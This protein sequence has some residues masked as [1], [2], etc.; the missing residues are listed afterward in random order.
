VAQ[1]GGQELAPAPAGSGTGAGIPLRLT[2]V[3]GLLAILLACVRMP[4]QVNN[5][6]DG[7]LSAILT[8]GRFAAAGDLYDHWRGVN[9]LAENFQPLI[10]VPALLFPLWPSP[11]LPLLFDALLSGLAVG[12]GVHW[13]ALLLR[14]ARLAVVPGMLLVL[15]SGG[16]PGPG[17]LLLPVLLALPLQRPR[18]LAAAV[19]LLL[20][21]GSYAGTL[22]L[23]PALVCCALPRYRRTGLILLVVSLLAIAA[24]CTA[25]SF[26]PQPL[27]AGADSNVLLRLVSSG[28]LAAITAGVTVIIRRAEDCGCWRPV[29]LVAAVMTILTVVID[30]EPFMAELRESGAA[31]ARTGELLAVLRQHVPDARGVTLAVPKLLLPRVQPAL[32]SAASE[33]H[34][35]PWHEDWLLVDAR[36]PLREADAAF[37]QTRFAQRLARAVERGQ[38]GVVYCA[39]DIILLKRGLPAQAPAEF[40]AALDRRLAQAGAADTIFLTPATFFGRWYRSGFPLRASGADGGI[41]TLPA[42]VARLNSTV[43]V[44]ALGIDNRTTGKH[45]R[46]PWP[47]D[48]RYTGQ[49]FIP[50]EVLTA[51]DNE[52]RLTLWNGAAVGAAETVPVYYDV[53]PPVLRHD[54][55][56]RWWAG[57]DRGELRV[58]C[59]Q[60]S[61][62]VRL[63]TGNFNRLQ[64]VNGWAYGHPDSSRLYRDRAL[65]TPARLAIDERE[66][67]PDDML[68]LED[69]A[70]HIAVYARG[71]DG[72]RL[73]GTRTAPHNPETEGLPNAWEMAAPLMPLR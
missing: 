54:T 51:G 36:A 37:F 27:S 34:G 31:A 63:L 10:I 52:L 53:Q 17:L 29:L 16:M 70:G 42:G 35:Q 58:F 7:Y 1:G 50:N 46:L 3:C 6:D 57:D 47:D 11:Y 67:H 55:Q 30:A 38:Y 61:R 26:L 48:C 24:A 68:L 4:A 14:D 62:P 23:W 44:T 73:L 5:P 45:A 69:G 71:Q 22:L 2:L 13:C 59:W 8:V 40:Y 60:P 25:T 43:R 9:Y 41:L 12:C 21:G 56:G 19:L 39:D 20:A 33:D 65:A 28:L 72:W 15:G 32:L 64:N 18:L 49:L 66:L